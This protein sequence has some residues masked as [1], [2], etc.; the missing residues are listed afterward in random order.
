LQHAYSLLCRGHGTNKQTLYTCVSSAGCRRQERCCNPATP[1]GAILSPAGSSL[2]RPADIP[3]GL[4][5]ARPCNATL[6]DSAH[7]WAMSHVS[8]PL[9]LTT[10]KD[11]A[12][13]DVTAPWRRPGL[14]SGVH[15]LGG[16]PQDGITIGLTGKRCE[17]N[18]SQH[19][20]LVGAESITETSNFGLLPRDKSELRMSSEETECLLNGAV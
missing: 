10:S 19:S 1:A 13:D 12:C 4:H 17:G 16:S 9:C 8:I 2:P 5:T 20:G 6:F 14:G 3:L 15:S 7:Q 11:R 18:S